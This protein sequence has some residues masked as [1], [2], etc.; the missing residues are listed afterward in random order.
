MLRDPHLK[1][2]N[3]IVSAH[4]PHLSIPQV[5]GLSLWSFGI[6][7]ARTSSLTQVSDCIARLNDERPNTV[8]QR[9]KEWYQE[10]SA[11][12]G[13][14]RWEWQP[15]T[16]FAP[17]LS[18]VLSLMPLSCR[19]L[20]FAMDVTT[21]KDRLSVLSVSILDRGS[22]IPV[23]WKILKGNQP[24]GWRP[25]WE[26]LFSAL[27]DVIPKDWQI[28]V[29]ADR[30]L[31]ADW[32]YDAIVALNWH[33]FLRINHRP[34]KTVQ[35][36]PDGDWQPLAAVVQRGET[37]SGPVRCFRSNPIKCTLLARWDER[38]TDPWLVLTDL[39]AEQANVLWYSYRTWVEDGY[40]DFKSDGWQWHH[41]RIT[42]PNRAERHW[43]AMAVATLWM[44]T[45][46]TQAEA[47]QAAQPKGQNPQPQR[48][49][50]Q[51][52]PSRPLSCFVLGML[53]LPF[54]LM[55]QQPLTLPPLVPQVTPTIAL[56]SS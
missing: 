53:V 33:P 25:Y 30:G 14:H 23:A 41:S 20:F 37:W 27:Q 9:L 32:L 51:R 16:C 35:C 36:L 19:E 54:L 52:P 11:K 47:Q 22:A 26:Q 34:D 13:E 28:V 38:Y 6:A 15:Q 45:L 46:G 7:V 5:T 29:C 10:A 43:L 24:D 44:L 8:R 55:R 1:E 21:Q 40:R 3:R 17:L 48:S 12:S 56:N 31:Y 18:W 49:R 4:F 2:W 42:D 39:S 50:P